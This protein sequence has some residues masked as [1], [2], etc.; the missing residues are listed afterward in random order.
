MN[1]WDLLSK[2][3]YVLLADSK[4]IFVDKGTCKKSGEVIISASFRSLLDDYYYSRGIFAQYEKIR[5][6][7]FEVFCLGLIQPYSI[8]SDFPL[9]QN[10]DDWECVI[11]VYSAYGI[12][13]SVYR[14]AI[15]SMA[16]L[17]ANSKYDIRVRCLFRYISYKD[18]LK[19]NE[20]EYFRDELGRYLFNEFAYRKSID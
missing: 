13:S 3:V 12:L 16:R 1:I 9:I 20:E 6:R 5:K 19:L 11:E 4:A 2:D 14:F 8:S 18:L 7:E 10:Y 17:A 15:L